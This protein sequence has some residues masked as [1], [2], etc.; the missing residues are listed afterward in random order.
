MS[1]PS[2][3][4]ETTTAL[5]RRASPE[6]HYQAFGPH[7]ATAAPRRERQRHYDGRAYHVQPEQGATAAAPSGGHGMRL[8]SSCV[9]PAVPRQVF[10]VGDVVMARWE[11]GQDYTATVVD[12]YHELQEKDPERFPNTLRYEVRYALDNVDDVVGEH[13]V[14]TNYIDLSKEHILFFFFYRLYKV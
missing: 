9:S 11:D 13:E 1:L 14:R 2:A 7:A 3:D 4:R 5:N 6:S 8:R 10:V 12:V